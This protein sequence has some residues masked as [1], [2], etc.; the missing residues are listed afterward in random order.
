MNDAIGYHEDCIPPDLLDT[1]ENWLSIHWPQAEVAFA[2]L[3]DG[4]IHDLK[5][6]RTT[7]TSVV[8]DI[9][10][11]AALVGYHRLGILAHALASEL[12]RNGWGSLAV[13]ASPLRRL[14]SAL[15]DAIRVRLEPAAAKYHD[16]LLA[17]VADLLA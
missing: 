5:A 3:L 15:C 12:R 2:A 4:H 11:I 9:A 6:A 7:V 13:D 14:W 10:G 16:R 1:F 17:S 8:H